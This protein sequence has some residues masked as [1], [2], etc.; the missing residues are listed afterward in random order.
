MD[1]D[2]DT[3]NSE[4]FDGALDPATEVEKVNGGAS[5]GWSFGPH[6]AWGSIEST[7][8]LTTH[9]SLFRFQISLSFIS[10]IQAFSVSGAVFPTVIVSILPNSGNSRPNDHNLWSIKKTRP[11]VNKRTS[12]Y[13]SGPKSDTFNEHYRIL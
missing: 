9:P 11:T 6:S 4:Y 7:T 12:I 2:F 3:L 10:E 5:L 13:S 8:I 1:T